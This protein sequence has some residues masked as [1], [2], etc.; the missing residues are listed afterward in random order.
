MSFWRFV[1]VRLGWALLGLWIVATFMFLL[2]FVWS[3]DPARKACGGDQASRQ[4]I[5][6]TSEKLHLD[7]PLVEQYARY[8]WNLVRHQSPPGPALFR[9]AQGDMSSGELAREAVPATLSLVVP[10]LLLAA[11][12]G[13]LVGGA[14]ARVRW[15]RILDFPI[16]VAVGLSPVFLALVLSFYLGYKW[17]VAPIGGYCE[18][19]SPPPD[20]ANPPPGLGPST[21]TCGGAVDWATHLILPVITLSLYF[22]AVYTR[23]VRALVV[24]VRSEKDPEKKRKRRRRSSLL[25]ARSVG[26][27][28][29]FA[30][31]V[32]VFV[33][34]AFQIPGLGRNA[35]TSVYADSFLELQAYVL[36]ATFLAISVHF[37]VDVVVAALD[38][39]L[40]W[41]RPVAPRPKPA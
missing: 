14:L 29:G 19:F 7:S 39:S 10:S 22:A 6:L 41:K 16:Y 25:F 36:Y 13:V 32:G 5:D 17:D 23:V 20:L 27:D 33:E 15:R 37:V 35:L 24:Q 9:G 21:E 8:L 31:G 1:A 38:P 2:F 4:C 3:S 18:F 28:F 26:R 30:I 11:G 34:T 12:V 40:R